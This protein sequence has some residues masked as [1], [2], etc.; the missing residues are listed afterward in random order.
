[1]HAILP[2]PNQLFKGLYYGDMHT[3]TASLPKDI[4]MIHACKEPCHRKALNYSIRSLPTDHPHYLAY[5]NQHHLYLNIID[6]PI[7][8]F[9]LESFKIALNFSQRQISTRPLYIHCNQGQSRAPS[10]TLLIMAKIMRTLPNESYMAA[11]KIFE[12][13]HPYQPGAGIERFLCENWKKLD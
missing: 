3:C 4:A 2:T 10:L 13:D 1:M 6:P 5:E 8:L 9:K 7:P 12:E 11:R